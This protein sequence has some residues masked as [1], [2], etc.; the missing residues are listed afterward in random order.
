MVTPCLYFEPVMRIIVCIYCMLHSIIPKYIY[1]HL[2]KGPVTKVTNYITIICSI[3]SLVYALLAI[4]SPGYVTDVH[5]KKISIPSETVK[6]CPYCNKEKPERSHHCRICKKCVLKMD[7][8]CNMLG[9]CVNYFNQGHFLRFLLFLG[10]SSIS[11][12]FYNIY[13]CAVV[14]S[15]NIQ[16][17]YFQVSSYI[18]STILTAFV[19][20][21][22]AIQLKMQIY[23]IIE[24]ITSIESRQLFDWNYRGVYGPNPYS[25]NLRYNL[26]EVLG[27]QKYLFLWK[28]TGDGVM[29]KKSYDV[30]YWPLRSRKMEFVDYI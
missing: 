7:H 5:T 26:E 4:F 12:L 6:K 3:I 30:D 8:H 15:Q 2:L 27:P 28:P 21:I 11:M 18:T 23:N 19:I 16:I 10:I 1:M 17:T 9:V 24:N 20:I 29:F 22:I 13:F 25:Y 14:I